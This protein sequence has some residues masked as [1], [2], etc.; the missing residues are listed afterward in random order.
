MK[1]LKN[2]KFMICDNEKHPVHSF[3]EPVSYEIAKDKDNVAIKLEET[4]CSG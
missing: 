2:F 1:H 4:F 3:D